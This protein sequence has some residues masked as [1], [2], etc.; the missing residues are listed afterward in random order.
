V[1]F[2]WENFVC[3]EVNLREYISIM[4]K[5]AEV[6]VLAIGVWLTGCSK[7][8]PE[9]GQP[10]AGTAKA[11]GAYSI[12]VT[13][14]TSGDLTVI[15]S[16]NFEVAG[17]FPLGKRPR[18]IH[19]SPDGQ[20]I[21]VALSGSPSAPPGV[22]ESTLPPPDH[23]LDGI[24]VFEIGQHKVTRMIQSGN[25]PENFDLSKDGTRLFVS[26]EDDALASIIDLAAGK[27]V[28]S[29]KVGAEPEGV[30]LSPDGKLLYVTSENTGTV[31]AIDPVAG[32]EIKSFKVGRRPRSVAFLPDGSKAYVP[33]ENDGTVM[34]VDSVAHKVIRPIKLGEPGVIKPM[35]VLLSNDGS[36][37]FVSTG[38]GH[39]IFVI[40]TATNEPVASV[41]AGQ[42]PWGIALSPDGK[43]LFTANGPSNDVSVI[44]V[45][46][47]TVV[48]KV[49]AGGGPWGV[50][51]LAN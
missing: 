22:D 46:T 43:T 36:K 8:A 3:T 7:S 35:G 19:A 12:Y 27:V 40:D 42:R 5:S 1:F 37:L 6:F 21:Y 23:S 25:D 20:T 2:L 17:T 34:L 47:N 26:N 9:A 13:N 14:E 10:S 15:D 30:K 29:I 50:I 39:M 38:R 33:A 18:G 51:T 32:K 49:K 16:A 44:D 24:G 48:K 4:R 31:T 41:E 28:Q 11:R 45:A